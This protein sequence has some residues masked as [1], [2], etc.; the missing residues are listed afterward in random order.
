MTARMEGLGLPTTGAI[1]VL[2]L[3]I[4]SRGARSDLGWSAS[5]E[6]YW[7]SFG[8]RILFGLEVL[9]AT[10]VIRRAAVT[11]TVQSISVLAR[12]MLVCTFLGISLKAGIK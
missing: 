1:S 11:P 10:E 5:Y 12:I 7:A 9:V 8:R 4:A 6:P 3:L 2:S